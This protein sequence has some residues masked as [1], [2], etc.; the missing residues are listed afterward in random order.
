MEEK[1]SVELLTYTCIASPSSSTF[2]TQRT[3]LLYP[4]V[5]LGFSKPRCAMLAEGNVAGLGDSYSV[6]AIEEE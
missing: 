6:S 5:T 4:A 3:L 2:I 1:P